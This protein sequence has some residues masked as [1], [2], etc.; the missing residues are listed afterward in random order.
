MRGRSLI[1]CIHRFRSISDPPATDTKTP[2]GQPQKKAFDLV[3]LILD[4]RRDF[5]KNSGIRRPSKHEPAAPNARTCLMLFQTKLYRSLLLS[6]GSG[7]L[8]SLAIFIAPSFAGRATGQVASRVGHR[9]KVSSQVL[10]D[11]FNYSHYRALAK[12]GWII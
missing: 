1:A 9:K 5:G 11:D 2:R 6:I 12:H 3:A 7:T 4:Q 10:F 8:A